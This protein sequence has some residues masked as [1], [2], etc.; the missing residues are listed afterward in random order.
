[1][2]VTNLR[3][4]DMEDLLPAVKM[5]R[6]RHLVCVASLREAALDEALAQDVHDLAGAVRAGATAQYVAQRNA[7]HE[8]LRGHGVMVLDVACDQLAGALVE[9]YLAVKR[10]GLL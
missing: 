5:L 8:A 3:D 10:D 2:L 6:R 4:E 7:A 1:M 9:K